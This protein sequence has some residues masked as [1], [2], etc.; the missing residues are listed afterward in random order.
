MVIKKDKN[1]QRLRRHT[2]VRGKISGTAERPR[3]AVY[4]SNKNISAQI[5]DDVTGTTLCA[6]SS[7]E[8]GFEGIGSNKEAAKKVG[9]MIAERAKAKGIEVVVFDRG[10]YIYHG[11]VSELA[12]GAREAG[13]KF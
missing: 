4:R 6:A 13:L 5:I 7:A 10:G 11:R 1:V 12:A 3:L 2:R 8:K 9:A